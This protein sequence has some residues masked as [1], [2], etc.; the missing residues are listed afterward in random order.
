MINIILVCVFHFQRIK[1]IIVI[2][3]I[4]L[5]KNPSSSQHLQRHNHLFSGVQLTSVRWNDYKNSQ[6]LEKSEKM[7]SDYLRYKEYFEGLKNRR[8]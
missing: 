5:L 1:S 7:P 4:L 2:F 8:N 3:I 6:M